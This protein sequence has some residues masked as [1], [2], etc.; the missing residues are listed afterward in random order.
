MQKQVNF[1]V[2]A[3]IAILA[4]MLLPALNKASKKAQGTTCVNNLKQL[5]LVFSA[6]E[7]D[8]NGYLL[9]DRGSNCY[10]AHPL[11]EAGYITKYKFLFCPNMKDKPIPVKVWTSDQYYRTYGRFVLDA[12]YNS[13][14]GK[15]WSSYG[16]SDKNS[17]NHYTF[18]I[19]KQ[20]KYPSSFIHA[21][22]S[23]HKNGKTTRSYVAPRA[24]SQHNF[25]F[26]AHGCANFLY[27]PGNV[28]S[29]INPRDIRE[30]LLKNAIA[31]GEDPNQTLYAYKNRIEVTF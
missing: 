5:G 28:S 13:F 29:K 15:S 1:V 20:I 8:S 17:A 27:M 11:I 2:I 9:F 7:N 30:D 6:Y 18:W 4:G 23:R 22:D 12:A 3:I 10:W 26:D 16:D 31:D 25:D 21:G 24:S 14:L 19:L